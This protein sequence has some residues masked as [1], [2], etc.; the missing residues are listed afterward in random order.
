MTNH[1]K[2]RIRALADELG[3]GHRAAANIITQRAA[4]SRG[5]H[6]ANREP[7]GEKCTDCGGPLRAAEQASV[8]KEKT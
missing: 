7:F 4:C 6:V 8:A 2:K 3:I 5:G 1:R